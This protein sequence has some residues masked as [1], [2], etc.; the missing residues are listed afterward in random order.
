M[1]PTHCLVAV[2]VIA[3]PVQNAQVDCADWGKSGRTR[4]CTGATP[5]VVCSWKQVR[6]CE[7]EASQWR[8]EAGAQKSLEVSDANRQF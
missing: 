5:N 1:K 3:T 7:P 6:I 2:M 8:R 4:F